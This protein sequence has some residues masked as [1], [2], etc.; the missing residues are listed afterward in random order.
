MAKPLGIVL[1]AVFFALSICILVSVGTALLLPG[2]FMEIVWKLHPA[3][4]AEMM[5]YRAF[6]GAGFFAL[7]LAMLGASIGLFRLRRWGWWLAVTMF[8]LDGLG[9]LAQI[10]MGRILEGAIGV[11]VAAAIIYYLTR[12]MVRAAFA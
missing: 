12:P 7:A 8:G 4:R 10:V 9:D 6:M 1:I 5:P 2:S 11:T 3:R